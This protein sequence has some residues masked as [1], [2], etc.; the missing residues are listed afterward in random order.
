MFIIT[1]HW[2]LINRR[3]VLP[4]A[5]LLLVLVGCSPMQRVS[6]SDGIEST[7]AFK[8]GMVEKGNGF[9]PKTW[10]YLNLPSKCALRELSPDLNWALL[11][12]TNDQTSEI[13]LA[14]I[15]DQHIEKRRNIGGSNNDNLRL[16]FNRDSSGL[17]NM[18]DD[19]WSLTRL[20]DGSVS[21]E[22]GNLQG[23]PPQMIS[24]PG[25]WSYD[26]TKFADMANNC[27]E[28]IVRSKDNPKGKFIDV[29][30]CNRDDTLFSFSP[31][32]SQLVYVSGECLNLQEK[33]DVFIIDIESKE[34]RKIYEGDLISGASW[35][36][37]GHWIAIREESIR[38][39][40]GNYKTILSLV[41]PTNNETAPI[42]F[43]YPLRGYD[44]LYGW[45]DLLWS[46]NNSMIA[47]YGWNTETELGPFVVEIPS[48]RVIHQEKIMD[49]RLIGWTENSQSVLLM[50]TTP[51][52]GKVLRFIKVAN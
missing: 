16:S 27:N 35:A 11:Q 50:E 31:D 52:G 29:G 42:K 32:G 3:K 7:E 28:M 4:I 43:E 23:F 6:P 44:I 1:G 26:G 2:L 12:C 46:P 37:N 10:A 19:Q 45:G 21:E 17:I 8:A 33:M 13:W 40:I 41:D 18:Q 38:L 51:E 49:G 5:L 48:G 22:D 14:Q 15:V 9:A 39:G 30:H 20:N 34:K 47:L 25:I 24:Y 36:P